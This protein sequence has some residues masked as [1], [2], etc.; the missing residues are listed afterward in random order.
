VTLGERLRQILDELPRGWSEASVIVTIADAAQ[1][2]RAAAMLGSLAPGRAG[3]RFVITITPAGA[4]G[5]SPD[6]TRRV[7]ERLD[8][9]GI[10]ARLSVPEHAATRAAEPAAAPS[11]LPLANRWDAMA[12]MLPPDWS[13]LYLEVELVSSGDT[14]RAALLLAP[15]NPFLHD[16]APA[17]FR[18]RAARRFGYG[19]A[20]QMVRRV[21]ARLDEDT[22]QGELRVLRVL[23]ETAPVL[24]QGPVWREAG[25]AL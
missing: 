21:L 4:A 17:R 3:T 15:V 6:A 23:C 9:E 11:R 22:I 18:F 19:A 14:D 1:A 12:A 10:D 20:P 24:T 8:R 7:L 2:D 16:A 5:P 25:R 13:D